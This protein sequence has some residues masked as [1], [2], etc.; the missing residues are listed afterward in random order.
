V[1]AT[2]E[3]IARV[4]AHTGRR[5]RRQ[6]AETTLL[7]PGHD[8]HKPSLSVREGNEGRPLVQ[9]RSHGCSYERICDAIGWERRNGHVDEPVAIYTYTDEQDVPLY[10]VGRF[11]G[12]RF[13]QRRAGADDW[14]GG[15]RGVRRVL[16]RLPLVVTAVKHGKTVYL[17]EGEKDVHTLEDA[18]VAIATTSPMGAGKWRAEYAETLRG[19]DVVVVA[20]RDEKGIEHA[21]AVARS[22]RRV[23]CKV[24]LRLPALNHEKA[25]VTDHLTAGF[26]LA[27]LVEL[28]DEPAAADRTQG[29]LAATPISAIAMR[30]I[31]W[32]DRPL[33][34]QSAFTL[35]AGPKGAGKGTYLAGLAARVSHDQNVLFVSSEDSVAIDLKPRLVAADA[36]ID[37]CY[38]IQQHVRLPDDVYELRTLAVDQLHGVGLLVI[39]PVANHIGERN[40]NND[41]EVR[42]AI[43]PL[44]W[45]ADELACLLIGV[46]HPGKDRSRGALAS[47]LGSTAWVDTPRA[48]V[49]IAVDDEDEDVRHIQ[50]VAGNRSR[51]GSAQS[52]KIDAVPIDGL[53]EPITIAVPLGES[54]K[55]VDELLSAGTTKAARDSR[56]GEARELILDVLEGD[57]EQESDTL[58]ARVA[59][60]T[61]LSART[62][63]NARKQLADEGLL[64]SRPERDE[65][66]TILCWKVYR[67]AAPR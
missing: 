32:F 24:R 60:E 33:W 16:Y 55:S 46:R 15:I 29:P 53:T 11:A 59:R 26:T 50:V 41:A 2:D 23:G 17:V 35:L 13:L 49:M 48:V 22:L 40:S 21:R 1:T 7:C 30:S 67:S 8:D 57:G 9:C 10:E 47:I 45:L 38:V 3:F 62:A 6:G 28:A 20:D 34:Q 27:Q 52:F 5:G 4:E 61:G 43:A 37:H 42:D 18:G 63:R 36:L 12:K 31:E 19:A 64:K 56:T 25:D 66:G 58:D 65:Y 39:D 44:N 54:S 14:K 51:N